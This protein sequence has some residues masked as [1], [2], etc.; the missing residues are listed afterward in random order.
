VVSCA[1]GEVGDLGA[2]GRGGVVPSPS[3]SSGGGSSTGGSSSASTGSAST[4]SSSTGSSGEPPTTCTQADGPYGCCAGSTLYY[5]LSN[6]GNSVTIHSCT[7]GDVCGWSESDGFYDCVS[8]PG[9]ADPSGKYP[10]ACN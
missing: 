2:G 6:S 3:S 4:S 8:A 10:E 9:G 5:C 7:H 1:T